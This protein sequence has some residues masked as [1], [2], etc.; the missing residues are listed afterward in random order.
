MP[1][2][3]EPISRKFSLVTYLSE[4]QLNDVLL[5]HS[6]QIKAWAY[7]YHD[8]DV[9]DDGSLKVKHCHVVLY[10]YNSST[11]SR[12]RKWFRALDS[13]GKEV[14]TTGQVC[15]DIFGM[16]D[17]LIH[18]DN[19]EKY[20]YPETIRNSNMPDFFSGESN[21]PDDNSLSIVDDMLSGVSI[22]DM[23]SRYGRDF[24][25]HFG[26][27]SEVIKAIRRQSEGLDPYFKE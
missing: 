23:V 19:P 7:A 11:V 25:I 5:A 4:Q 15:S 1:S 9:N 3:K 2:K 22:Y 16:W 27:Y 12:I 21:C 26:H 8:K 24:C 17:Y 18:A 6:D 20:Q 13:D 10:V 14:T